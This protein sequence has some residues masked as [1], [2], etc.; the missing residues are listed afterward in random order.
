MVTTIPRPPRNF[1]GSVT[2]L[3][4][5]RKTEKVAT[6]GYTYTMDSFA[7]L[8]E[9]SWIREQYHNIAREEI[10]EVY[11]DDTDAYQL[12]VDGVAG[13]PI[14]DAKLS[15]SGIIAEPKGSIGNL[16]AA[17]EAA[18]SYL[19]GVVPSSFKNPTGYYMT[20]GRTA[21]FFTIAV[22]GREV[23]NVKSIRWERL[24]A[25]SNIKIW[26]KARYAS[27][28][29]AMFRGKFLLGARNAAA[30]FEGINAS[31]SYGNPVKLGQVIQTAKA[32]HNFTPLAVPV[33]EIGTSFSNVS[34]HVGNIE[35]NLERGR[36]RQSKNLIE[37][38]ILSQKRWLPKRNRRR[39][40]GL[41]RT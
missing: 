10:Q 36:K 16:R 6:V 30:K 35:F 41:R 24:T 15:G 38:G 1:S 17:V 29:E 25:Q 7:D 40:P 19:H 32:G 21:Q 9:L 2:G 27:P 33:V 23:N 11:G 4:K 39:P 12:T 22:N 13:A 20:S 31:F 14:E 28:V 5:F 3:A 8:L 18:I 34:N 37:R 26:N